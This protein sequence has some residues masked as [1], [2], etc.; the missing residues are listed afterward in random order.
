MDEEIHKGIFISHI[1]KIFI[2]SLG[3]YSIYKQDWIWAFASFF[4]FLLSMS[5][6]LIE[7]SLKISL[8]WTLDLLIVV[9]LML[10]V[11]GGVLGLY[12]I[13]Y[14]DKIAHFISSIIIAFLALIIIYVLDMYWEGLKMDL[15]MIGFFIIIFTIALGG[16]WEIGEFISDEIIVG[17]PKAQVSLSDTMMDLIYDSI[18]GII[19]GV[20]GTIG[21]RRGDFKE[22]ISQ[23]GKEAKKWH[24]KRFQQAKKM[25]M[26]SLQKALK[27]GKV[28]EKVMPI[29]ALLNGM[30]DFF[31]TSSCSGRIVVMEIP[32]IGKKKD[33]HFLGKWHREVNVAEV[34]DAIER[35]HQGEI[36]LL[37]QSPIFHVSTLSMEK[38]KGLMRVALQSGFKNSG[39][40]SVNGRIVVE[41][42]S[43]ERL[44]FIIVKNGKMMCNDLEEIVKIANTMMERIKEKLKRLEKNISKKFKIGQ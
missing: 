10:H 22:I 4:A 21:I 28:D 32:S 5:P 8:P 3:A 17:A 35:H 30:D 19:V 43:T 42:C 41:L 14:Y 27:E 36:W 20:G 11:W 13:P 23:L 39:I 16:I 33:A 24:G 40:K 26:E 2:F 1:L 12:S 31:T 38:A 6:L 18:A 15:F 25:A 37:V 9:P 34:K 44:D 7:R 29:L